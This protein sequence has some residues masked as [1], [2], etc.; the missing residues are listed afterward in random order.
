MRY[1]RFLPT[2][3]DKRPMGKSRALTV[4]AYPI[5]T[6]CVVGKSVEKCS[7]ILGRITITLPTSATETKRPVPIAR[8]EHHL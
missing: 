4:N 3:S 6:H 2:M 1:I 5:I 7:A 8:N